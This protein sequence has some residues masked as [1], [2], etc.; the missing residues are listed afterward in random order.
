M[1]VLLALVSSLLWGTSDFLGGTAARR[2]P[3]IVVVGASQSLALVLLVGPA[4]L[5]GSRPEHL[6]AGPVAGLAGLAGL[7]A[8]YSALAAGTMGVIAP[9]A[10]SG[11]AVPVVVGLLRGDSPSGVQVAGIALALLGAVLASGPELSGG[12]SPRPL[13]LAL[14]AAACFGSVAVLVAE[15]SKGGSGS[16]VTTL[17]LMRVASVSAV[18][19]L[20]SVTRSSSGLARG[21][22]RILLPISVFDVAA[23]ATFA[24]ASREGLLSVTSVL[25][26][27]YPVVTV[28]LARQLQGERLR[29]LQVAGVIGTLGGVALLAAG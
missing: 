2:L 20:W 5:L 21:D 1:P 8:F 25:A 24:V 26:S 4:V 12:A 6:W 15:G 11:A 29:S 13:L 18:L 27:L 17:T 28:L 10:A 14:G 16:V 3:S 7:A 9:I 19:L 23:N 22:L